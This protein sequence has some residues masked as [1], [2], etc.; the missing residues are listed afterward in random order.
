MK[1][2]GFY[3]YL[4][5]I[6]PKRFRR[7]THKYRQFLVYTIFGTL[8]TVVNFLIFFPLDYFFPDFLLLN[9]AIAWIGSTTF[10]FISNKIIVFS[11][12]TFSFKHILKQVSSFYTS[13]L[14]A[15]GLEEGLLSVFVY[16]MHIPS[17]LSK[18]ISAVIVGFV[19]YG[20]SKLLIF[21]KPKPKPEPPAD[22]ADDE[23]GDDLPE[24]I[25]EDMERLTEE[26]EEIFTAPEDEE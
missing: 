22:D 9:N 6:I 12:R 5:K 20:I 26:D 8:T 19:N 11:D 1:G 15:L 4:E 17:W 18:F 2:Q 14:L 7:Y 23:D 25:I 21:R 24:Y 3:S 10:S 13:R 16:L